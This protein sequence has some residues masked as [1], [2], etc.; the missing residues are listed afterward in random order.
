MIFL[1]TKSR[2]IGSKIIQWGL[3][4]PASHFA[5]V[6]SICP[7]R[8]KGIVFHSE[9]SGFGLDWLQGYL[10]T[11]DIVAALEPKSLTS[12]E[13]HD[14]TQ[15]II[16]KL[17]GREYDKPAF[18]Y[19]TYRAARRKLFGHPLPARNEWDTKDILCTGIATHLYPLK[20][21]WF[22]QPIIDGDIMT[23]WALYQNM[24]ES[25]QFY[26]LEH[27]SLL[28]LLDNFTQQ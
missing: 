14:I 6:Y 10:K 26:H 13:E 20:P 27:N 22:S 4:E 23:P 21:D 18:A 28:P 2:K 19:F 17:Y 15:K 5:P 16:T 11:V 7:K 24:K 3:D 9:F 25:E 8:T 1:F 12:K